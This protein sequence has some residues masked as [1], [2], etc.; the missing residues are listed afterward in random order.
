[1]L[2]FRLR[3]YNYW[4]KMVA[5]EWA[6]VHYIEIDYQQYSLLFCSKAKKKLDSLDEVDEI[7]WKLL[8]S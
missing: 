4:Q 2:D 3:A 6:C 7:F 5:P 1:M 8:K